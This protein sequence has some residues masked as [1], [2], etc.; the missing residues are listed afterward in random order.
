ML[1]VAGLR[2]MMQLHE[3]YK[4]IESLSMHIADASK[5]YFQPEQLRQLLQHGAFGV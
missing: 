3:P 4:C 2:K 5:S 1:S